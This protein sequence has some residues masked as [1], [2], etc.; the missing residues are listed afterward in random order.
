LDVVSERKSFCKTYLMELEPKCKRWIQIT[1][2]LK[3]AL[4]NALA[5]RPGHDFLLYGGIQMCEYHIDDVEDIKEVA[6]NVPLTTSTR[7][8]PNVCPLLILGQDECVFLQH[9]FGQKQWVTPTGQRP[10]MPKTEGDIWMMSV[11]QCRDFGFGR[12]MTD[13][14]LAR[15]NDLRK[16]RTESHH[17][18]VDASKAIN[19]TTKKLSLLESPFVKYIHVG[20]NNDGCWN[21]MQHVF[22]TGGCG[23]L[24][25]SSVP[26]M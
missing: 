25:K 21:S 20:I 9:L 6:M 10:I 22:A 17:V 2:S 4:G 12:P 3:E 5:D 24:L 18:D 11:L 15:V 19:K 8:D 23:R 13:D 14:E 16:E 1:K 7:V 26:T